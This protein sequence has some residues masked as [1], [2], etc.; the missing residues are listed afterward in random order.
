MP[1]NQ[2]TLAAPTTDLGTS[3]HPPQNTMADGKIED[4]NAKLDSSSPVGATM[5]PAAAVSQ[6]QDLAM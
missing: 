6:S 2:S 3:D 4:A 5:P 1:V